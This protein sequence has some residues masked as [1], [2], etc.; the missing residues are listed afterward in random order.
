[1]QLVVNIIVLAAIYALTG[2][3]IAGVVT[4]RR[5]ITY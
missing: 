5:E 1:L 3:L 4:L 2:M